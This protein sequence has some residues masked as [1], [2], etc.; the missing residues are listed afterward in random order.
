[1]SAYAL[2]AGDSG[3]RLP[4]FGTWRRPFDVAPDVA[5][6]RLALLLL[7]VVVPLFNPPL[8][9][10]GVERVYLGLPLALVAVLASVRLVFELRYRWILA[11]WAFAAAYALEAGLLRGDLSPGIVGN[12]YRPISAVVVFCAC[13]VCLRGA[14]RELWIRLFLLGGLVGCGLA[15][16]HAMV[17]AIDPFGPSRANPDA[18]FINERREE[19][20]FSY[21]GN[22]G[23]YAAYVSIVALVTMERLRVR[24]L[25]PSLYTVSAVVGALAIAASGSRAAALAL[26]VA[27]VVIGV[28]S[29]S[30]RVPLVIGGAVTSALA[31]LVLI[32]AGASQEI[33]E[34]RVNEADVSADL[35]FESWHQALDRFRDNPLFGSGVYADT[36]DG[37]LFYLL[38]VGGLVGLA[39]VVAMYWLTL[40]RPL[41]LRDWTGL[42]LILGAASIGITQDVLGTPLHTWALAAGVFLLAAPRTLEPER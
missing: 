15:V 3:A 2:L 25:A 29:A 22:L 28:R 35:R 17:P 1:V 4:T 33:V 12:V 11:A 36:T 14:D 37:T 40:I 39:L 7:F 19:G 34:S 27:V 5:V 31:V 10:P 21:P 8:Y 41:R 9:E 32:A 26:L 30:L 13:V 24:P 23:P 18:L 38:A 16:L 42:P 20:A 6:G